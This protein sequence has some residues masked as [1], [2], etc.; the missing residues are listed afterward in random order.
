MAMARAFV[1]IDALPNRERDVFDALGKVQAIVGRRLLK[2]RL[3][4][5][6]VIA[7]LEAPDEDGLE[8]LITNELRSVP[9]VHSIR[10]VMPHH[11]LFG[12]VQREMEELHRE[13]E[14]RKPG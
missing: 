10:R 11:T 9:W 14:A 6:D 8:R 4:Q 5:G 2:Q 1:L 3:G 13:A 12:P 7:L